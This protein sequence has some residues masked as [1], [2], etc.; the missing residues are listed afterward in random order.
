MAYLK[1]GIEQGRRKQTNVFMIFTVVIVHSFSF[2]F[3]YKE[4]DEL[5]ERKIQMN[6]QFRTIAGPQ[7][8]NGMTMIGTT[9]Y[10][11]VRQR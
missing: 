10:Q 11:G 7:Q 2:V 9:G 5:Q 8:G 3:D 6:E 1:V 4:F